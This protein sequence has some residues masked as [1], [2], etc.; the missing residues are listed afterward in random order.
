MSGPDQVACLARVLG[1]EISTVDV[2]PDQARVRCG[3]PAGTFE[4]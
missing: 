3:R 2:P 1:R 4:G